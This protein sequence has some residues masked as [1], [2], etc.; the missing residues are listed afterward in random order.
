[1]SYVIDCKKCGNKFMK[2][3]NGS[4][5]TKC[6]SCRT[7]NRNTRISQSIED[8]T[9]TEIKNLLESM[10]QKQDEYDNKIMIFKESVDRIVSAEVKVAVSE[11]VKTVFDSE[12]AELF[13]MKLVE[14]NNRIIVLEK[15]LEKIKTK[16]KKKGEKK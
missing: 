2:V 1:M 7:R 6:H 5:E 16:M 14:M 11:K 3:S 8:M 10:I 13:K 4:T 12:V 15:D 9:K